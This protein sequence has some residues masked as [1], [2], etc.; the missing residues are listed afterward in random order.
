MDPPY[1][2]HNKLYM[3]IFEHIFPFLEVE[4]GMLKVE[5]CSWD[6]KIHILDNMSRC[7]LKCKRCCPWPVVRFEN[8]DS[9]VRAKQSLNGADIY[10]GCC[11]L[12]IEYAKV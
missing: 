1:F 7:V 9:A 2:T 5:V 11:T 4:I 10:S 3:I 8:T 12:R 6:Y